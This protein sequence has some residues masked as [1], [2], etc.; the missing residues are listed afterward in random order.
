VDDA[1]TALLMTRFYQNLLGRREEL[2]RP[3]PM[4]EALAEAKNWLRTRT[5]AEVDRLCKN[6]PTAERIDRVSGPRRSTAKAARPY[7]HPYFW[8]A[9]ILIGDPD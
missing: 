3:L 9:F 6:L 1:A 5:A 2:D 7:D 8:A 4:A